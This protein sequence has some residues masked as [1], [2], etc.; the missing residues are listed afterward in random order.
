M[1]RDSKH[2]Y[3][4]HKA[5]YFVTEDKSTQEKTQFIYKVFNINTAVVGIN[6]FITKFS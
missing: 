3:Y 2:I 1:V 4:A 5:N 6:E